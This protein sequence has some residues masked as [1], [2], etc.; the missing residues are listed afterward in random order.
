MG[1]GGKG[2]NR[3]AVPQEI[4]CFFEARLETNPLCFN[5][6]TS[7][8][9][10]LLFI[11]TH[12]HATSRPLWQVKIIKQKSSFEQVTNL[13]TPRGVRQYT[14]SDCEKAFFRPE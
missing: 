13:R 8:S 14:I 11:T 9:C 3:T 7:A 4:Q 5:Q 2:A 10:N 12:V 6:Y 1:K